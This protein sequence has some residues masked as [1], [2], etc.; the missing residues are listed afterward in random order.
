MN[1][2]CGVLKHADVGY[3]ELDLCSHGREVLPIHL[4]STLVKIFDIQSVDE[5][6]V[7]VIVEETSNYQRFFGLDINCVRWK[8]FHNLIY[9][10]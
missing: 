7:S 5:K 6:I 4:M 10:A 2:Q 9:K 1:T 3:I 8:V